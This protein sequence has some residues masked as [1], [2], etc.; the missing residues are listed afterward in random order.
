MNT[1]VTELQNVIASINAVIVVKKV[2]IEGLQYEVDNFEYSISESEYNDFLDQSY[3][4]VNI[5]GLTYSASYAL[6]KLDPIAYNCS[7]SDYES[8]FDL[9]DS[10]EYTEKCDELEQLQDEL[11]SLESDLQVIRMSFKMK[12]NNL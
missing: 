2:V 10:A 11:E 3:D 7:K 5:C 8:N 12:L 6:K 1:Q 9:N 4:E